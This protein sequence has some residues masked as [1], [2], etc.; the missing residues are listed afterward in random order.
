MMI[1]LAASSGT[2]RSEEKSCLSVSVNMLNCALIAP[3][4]KT[5]TT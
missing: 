1:A 4:A 3:A 2:I 5:S